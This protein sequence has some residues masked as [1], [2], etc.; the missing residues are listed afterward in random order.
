MGE[1]N[2]KA[3][4]LWLVQTSGLVWRCVVW[5]SSRQRPGWHLQRSRLHSS[6]SP[7]WSR[8]PPAPGERAQAHRDP[9]GTHLEKKNQVRNAR[10]LKHTFQTLGAPLYPLIENLKLGCRIDLWLNSGK[11]WWSSALTEHIYQSHS[12]SLNLSFWTRQVH[13][14]I[15]YKNIQETQSVENFN[16][17]FHAMHWLRTAQ[18][19]GTFKNKCS[20]TE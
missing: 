11:L 16:C 17:N 13:I 10:K 6:R 7:A 14:A 18:H 1:E 2:I 15:I 12:R 3:L 20:L 5:L 4:V 9:R 8:H 19:T